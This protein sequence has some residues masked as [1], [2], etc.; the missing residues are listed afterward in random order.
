MVYKGAAVTMALNAATPWLASLPAVA[1]AVAFCWGGA[2]GGLYTLTV[3]DIGNHETGTGLFEATAVLVLT[4]TLGAIAAPL[5]GAM[6][7]Q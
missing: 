3:I 1:I 7:M 4:Y 6:V 2:G 5:M